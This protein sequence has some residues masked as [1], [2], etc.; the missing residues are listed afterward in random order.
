M[1]KKLF[2]I[3]A[4][5]YVTLNI[6]QAYAAQVHGANGDMKIEADKITITVDSELDYTVN[7]AKVILEVYD[8]VTKKVVSGPTTIIGEL[9]ETQ[10]T[11]SIDISKLDR[12]RTYTLLGK[13]ADPKSQGDTFSEPF[14]T[15]SIVAGDGS[16][17]GSGTATPENCVVDTANFYPYGE[18][19]DTFYKEKTTKVSIVVHTKNCANQE[20]KLTVKEQDS[21]IGSIVPG[22]NCNDALSDSKLED[23]PFTIPSTEVFSLNYIA[24]EENCETLGIADGYDCLYYFELTTPNGEKWSS[25]DKPGGRIYYECDG[26]CQSEWETLPPTVDAVDIGAMD[27]RVAKDEYTLLA[28][29]GNIKAI[30]G[31]GRTLG[32]YIN[33]MVKIFLG[34]CGALAV[35]M[36]IIYGVQWMG[37]D[38]VFG[39]TEA[40]QHIGGALMGLVLALGSWML[41]NT[42]NP[43]LLGGELKIGQVSVEIEGDAMEAN[44]EL[45]P[46][47][48][49]AARCPEGIYL[50]T[51]DKGGVF[52][53]CKTMT[54][55]IKNMI[56]SAWNQNMQ[57]TGFGFR[58]KK[59]QEELRAQNCGGITNVYKSSAKCKPDTAIPGTSMHESGLAFD[60]RC[61]GVKISTHDNKCYI[62]LKANANKYGLKNLSSEPWH[63][64]TTGH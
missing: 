14:N 57:I 18:S 60:L 40:K 44:D 50:A 7:K 21:C 2:I 56:N 28:P 42:V 12:S 11:G 27:F 20:L 58:S 53:T 55:N 49:A 39:K 4:I 62:W 36:I 32:D 37:T 64:S 17:A 59:R 10:V 31:D 52:P 33:L 34:I 45:P 9:G 23:A 51:T 1:K 6:N 8:E 3:F 22:M 41:L 47:G 25:M 26:I 29:I 48:T 54:E 43:D 46:T 38:S 15:P 24:G 30:G 13:D 61:E 5:F 16:T 19:G 35:I 63:W